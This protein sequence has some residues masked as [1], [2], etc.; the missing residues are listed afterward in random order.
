MCSS[1]LDGLEELVAGDDQV[2]IAV[3]EG[4]DQLVIFELDTVQLGDGVLMDEVL[5]D[6]A[7]EGVLIDPH[8]D[9]DRVPDPVVHVLGLGVSGVIALEHGA[10]LIIE[11]LA[12][13]G[14]A[15]PMVGALEEL[16]GQLLFDAEDLPAHGG[17]G[18]MG[19]RGRPGEI[20]L[21]CQDQ[22]AA[23]ILDRKSVV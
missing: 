9:L 15:H 22:E 4:F 13:V 7:E 1:D 21:L 20:Q 17:L 2:H 19:L 23:Q 6:R 8:P 12:G 10:D 18:H 16:D 5:D 14:E 11:F 3:V